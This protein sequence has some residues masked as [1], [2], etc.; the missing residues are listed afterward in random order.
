MKCDIAGNSC[1]LEESRVTKITRTKFTNVDN[2]NIHAVPKELLKFDFS[3]FTLDF[4]V[5]IL[6]SEK[7]YYG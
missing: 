4:L 3:K 5:L 2:N 1:V 7:L 6:Y